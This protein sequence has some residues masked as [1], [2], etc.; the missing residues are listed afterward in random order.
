MGIRILEQK[1]K[2]PEADVITEVWG[3]QEQKSSIS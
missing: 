1:I 2:I 3:I